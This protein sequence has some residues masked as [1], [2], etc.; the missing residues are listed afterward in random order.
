MYIQVYLNRVSK[1]GIRGA[2]IV[3]P[4]LSY[5]S[6]HNRVVQKMPLSAYNS[7]HLFSR[8]FPLPSRT[9]TSLGRPAIFGYYM[10]PYEPLPRSV[11]ALST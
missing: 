2:S 11:S 7:V 5:C 6:L 3:R 4:E 8:E 9:E 10:P 1:N